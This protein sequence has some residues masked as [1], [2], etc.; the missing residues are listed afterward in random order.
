MSKLLDTL[1]KISKNEDVS[2]QSGE[3]S[4]SSS[5]DASR[6]TNLKSVT[7]MAF[8]I[9]ALSSYGAWPYLAKYINKIDAKSS[10]HGIKVVKAPP[11]QKKQKQQKVKVVSR[12]TSKGRKTRT[13]ADKNT[14][15]FVRFNQLAI[16]YIH[17]NQPWQGIYYF[18]KA[19][20]AAPNRIEPLIN[21]AVVYAELGYY[22][23]AVK[24]FEEAYKINPDFPPLRKNLRILYQANL[25]KG[26]LLSQEFTK[27]HARNKRK[28]QL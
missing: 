26:S 17:K 20:A 1:E 6:E 10:P 12:T 2:R 19:K 25:L 15:E 18:Q 4:A 22:P 23:K 27:T 3:K 21:A 13:T 16:Q 9:V 28:S 14:E 8:I 5:G 7:I 24:L 11:K